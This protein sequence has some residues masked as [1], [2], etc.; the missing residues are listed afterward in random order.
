MSHLSLVWLPSPACCCSVKGYKVVVPHFDWTLEWA[1]PT[2]V[3]QH[4]FTQSPVVIEVTDRN[5]DPEKLVYDVS[6][7]GGQREGRTERERCWQ[8]EGGSGAPATGRA[9]GGGGGDG[10]G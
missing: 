10:D 2:P 6:A 5:T 3:P 1:L 7:R 4:Q 8:R 9:R